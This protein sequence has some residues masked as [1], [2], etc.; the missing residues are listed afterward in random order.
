MKAGPFEPDRGA[1]SD[2]SFTR[3][4]RGFILRSG[5]YGEMGHVWAFDNIEDV[6]A[7]F[8]EQ[9]SPAPQSHNQDEVVGGDD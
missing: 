3:C 2:I 1:F 6:G 8:V 4:T 5:N 7:W 9:Y